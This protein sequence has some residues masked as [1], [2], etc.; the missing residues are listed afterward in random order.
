MNQK[1][2]FSSERL[3][4]ESLSNL[5]QKNP[6]EKTL[7]GSIIE[8]FRENGLALIMIFFALPIAIPLPYPP[9]FTTLFG[10]PL[11]ILS[12]QMILGF[13][14][15]K[16]PSRVEN[17]QIS[18]STLIMVTNK[19]IPL[20]RRIEKYLKPRFEFASSKYCEQF[21]GFISLICAIAIAI[22][23]PFTN[24]IPAWGITVMSLGLLGR[25]GLVIIVGFI[26]SVI[27]NFIAGA[28][29]VGSWYLIKNI[30]NYIF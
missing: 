17:L 11:V 19:A 18:N 7:V 5:A 23:L 21:I 16:L 4:S 29:V 12:I 10:L 22:P 13:H 9:G 15:V 27:G 20:L 30:I 1:K 6:D 25:D 3:A 2:S 14:R 24:S 26:I 28:A 8:E